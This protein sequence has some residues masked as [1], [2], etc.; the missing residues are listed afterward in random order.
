MANNAKRLR[1]GLIILGLAGV[2]GAA[3][4]V[5]RNIIKPEDG[6]QTIPSV[7]GSGGESGGG[8]PSA[9]QDGGEE[10]PGLTINLSDG[11][12]QPEEVVPLPVAHGEPLSLEEI[13]NIL[14]RLPP[15]QVDPDDRQAFRLPEEVLPPPRT[16]ET[17]SEIF[18][19]PPEATPPEVAEGPLEVLRYSPEG[20]VPIAPFVNVTFNQPMGTHL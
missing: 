11:G 6:G 7:S 19:L 17:I 5:G 8:A 12:A 3:Y 14:L 18:P 16:G 4:L 13:N 2:A 10:G 9:A 20:D 1:A 15:L